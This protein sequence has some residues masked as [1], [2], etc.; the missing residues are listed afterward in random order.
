MTVNPALSWRLFRLS[1]MA[2]CRAYDRHTWTCREPE[3]HTSPALAAAKLRVVIF[4]HGKTR[5]PTKK[6]WTLVLVTRLPRTYRFN[7]GCCDTST[8]CLRSAQIGTW[9]AILL[10]ASER[11]AMQNG[12]C[13]RST[14][15]LATICNHKSGP[16]KYSF[17]KIKVPFTPGFIISS[18]DCI[19]G[20]VIS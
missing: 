11:F 4:F 13:C 9:L 16:T 2:A 18:I 6:A 19:S 10:K 7:V 15:S 12:A 5:A 17:E 3:E 1:P 14:H 8:E 20:I